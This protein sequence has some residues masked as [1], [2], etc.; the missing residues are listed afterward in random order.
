MV[1]RLRQH[2][3]LISGTG[4]SH[5]S[6]VLW[7]FVLQPI[8]CLWTEQN[9]ESWIH[10]IKEMWLYSAIAISYMIWYAC[11]SKE[12]LMS[13]WPSTIHCAFLDCFC[14]SMKIC[15]EISAWWPY[16]YQKYQIR[17]WQLDIYSD[18]PAGDIQKDMKLLNSASLHYTST[19]ESSLES[20]LLCKHWHALKI[21]FS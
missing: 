18:L 6:T 13:P 17:Q 20:Q 11:I 10:P 5:F 8:T 1:R 19:A 9:A 15:Q 14:H 4:L 12:F 16:S 7:L 3:I 21:T 2:K